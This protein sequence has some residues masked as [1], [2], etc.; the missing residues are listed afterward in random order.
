[1]A[2]INVVVAKKRTIQVNTGT[3]NLVSPSSAVTLKNITTIATGVTKLSQL[4]DVD[5][6]NVAEGDTLVYNSSTSKYTAEPLDLNYTV[7]TL[8]GG[9]F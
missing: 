1:M 8:D 9:N 6:T 4:S 5:V 3:A 2:V 7:G